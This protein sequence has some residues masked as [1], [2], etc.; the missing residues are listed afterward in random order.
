MREEKAPVRQRW[1]YQRTEQIKGGHGIMAEIKWTKK[2]QS[3]SKR[4]KGKIKERKERRQGRWKS[5]RSRDKRRNE[6]NLKAED[7]GSFEKQRLRVQVPTM[8]L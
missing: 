6:A 8:W 1:K 7:S 3:G 5:D 2:R 4:R